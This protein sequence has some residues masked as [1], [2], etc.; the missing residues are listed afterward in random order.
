[1]ANNEDSIIE[2]NGKLS[3]DSSSTDASIQKII[4]SFKKL[5]QSAPSK[6]MKDMQSIAG[7]AKSLDK[8]VDKLIKN[9]SKNTAKDNIS[10]INSALKDQLDV[11]KKSTQ[12]V[13]QFSKALKGTAPNSKAYQDIL[14]N[15][16]DAQAKASSAIGGIVAGQSEKQYN[17]QIL[18][19]RMATNLSGA[20]RAVEMGG[21]AANFGMTQWGESGFRANMYRSQYNAPGQNMASQMAFDPIAAALFSMQGGSR[22]VRDAQQYAKMEA[23]GKPLTGALTRVVGS[24]LAGGGAMAATGAALGTVV[25]GAGNLVGGTGGAL[26]GTAVGAATQIGREISNNGDLLGVSGGA[27]R[28]AAIKAQQGSAL[29]QMVAS[30]QANT[31]FLSDMTREVLEKAPM[32]QALAGSF[33]GAGGFKSAMRG[34]QGGAAFGFGQGEMLERAQMLATTGISGEQR[35]LSKNK[36]MLNQFLNTERA[37]GISTQEQIARGGQFVGMSA[38]PGSKKALTE[39]S[40]AV[41]DGIVSGFKQPQIART[42]ASAALDLASSAKGKLNDTKFYQAQLLG[43][44]SWQQAGNVTHADIGMAQTAIQ[45]SNMLTGGQTQRSLATNL[46][47]ISSMAPGLDIGSQLVLSHMTNPAEILGDKGSPIYKQLLDS[48]GG[49]NAQTLEKKVNEIYNSNVSGKFSD[50]GLT[51]GSDFSEMANTKQ[52]QAFLKGIKGNSPDALKKKQRMAVAL[53]GVENVSSRQGE[54][55]LLA[56]LGA[57]GDLKTKGALTDQSKGTFE[58]GLAG[59]YAGAEN[60]RDA[61]RGQKGKPGE[62][63]IHDA[64]EEIIK[65]SGAMQKGM[66]DDPKTMFNKNLG[67]LTSATINILELLEKQFNKT[68]N[69]SEGVGQRMLLDTAPIEPPKTTG[70]VVPKKAI[71]HS[72][73]FKDARKH[74]E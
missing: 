41:K 67:D 72:S 34:I 57:S 10:K 20:G 49:G 42:F 18:N 61:L 1:M 53:A 50:L 69:T 68:V 44:T 52:R 45:K 22:Q 13:E 58:R 30:G 48:L 59:T 8:D 32:R 16:K 63:T 40:D 33:G 37:T 11:L 6:L 5:E 46:Y 17:Q 65:Q 74:W 2:I 23:E 64:I 73:S 31:Q 54:T 19:A 62:P 43:A 36:G 15:L 27:Q 21:M 7:V 39:F 12:Q 28:Q 56:F 70:T 3:L 35:D 26:I 38:D 4:S 47:N 25:P 55:D 51:L 66:M 24:G 14:K 71:P 60:A 29:Q 9:F